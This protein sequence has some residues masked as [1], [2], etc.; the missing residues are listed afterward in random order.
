MHAVCSWRILVEPC[1]PQIQGG[2]GKLAHSVHGCVVSEMVTD[3]VSEV[4]KV[5]HMFCRQRALG[6]Y[7]GAGDSTALLYGQTGAGKS[8]SVI[9]YKDRMLLLC[10]FCCK[11]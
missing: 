5:P 7:C 9:G 1:F 11:S 4:D 10:G 3:G 2:V 8:Y 6:R